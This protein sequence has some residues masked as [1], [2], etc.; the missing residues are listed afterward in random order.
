ML[1]LYA[2]KY[3]RYRR[4]IVLYNINLILEGAK[5]EVNKSNLQRIIV[6]LNLAAGF[7]RGLVN[8][9]AL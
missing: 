3:T 2:S 6:G 5:D 1:K 4:V 9:S 8:L 7:K